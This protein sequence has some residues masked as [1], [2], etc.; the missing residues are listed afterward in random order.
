MPKVFNSPRI[1]INYQPKMKMSD[2]AIGFDA[3]ERWQRPRR[4][5]VSPAVFIPQAGE[6]GLIGPIDE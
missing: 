2:E 4:G 5:P 3:L 6:T 1:S